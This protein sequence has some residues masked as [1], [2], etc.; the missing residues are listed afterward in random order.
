MGHLRLHSPPTTRKWKQVVGLLEEDELRIAEIAE[1]VERAADRSLSQA[2]NDPAFVEAL[3]LLLTMPT[4]LKDRDPAPALSELGI[5][6]P[7]EPTLTKILAAFGD[8][9]D[10][11]RQRSNRG[12]TDFSLLAR[13]AAI[14]ALM[15]MTADWEPRLWHATAEDQRTTIATFVSTE[16]FGELAQRFFT[17]I[18]ESH[19]HYF[20]DREVPR[21]IG[22]GSCFQSV[23]DTSAFETA[24]RKHCRETTLIMRV[25]ARDWLGANRHHLRK[26][27]TRSDAAGFASHAFTK[28]RNELYRRGAALA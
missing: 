14:T 10:R 15:E 18:L 17:N 1:A 24:V 11:A 16:H 27:L 9:I 28:V 26:D 22:H 20:L 12:V 2:V 6:V 21:H 4:A 7:A 5:N 19:L 8:S 13:N 25:F 23:A 3:W